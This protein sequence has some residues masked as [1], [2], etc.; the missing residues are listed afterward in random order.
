[1]RPVAGNP[2]GSRRRVPGGKIPPAIGRSNE[3]M[4]RYDRA[5]NIEKAAANGVEIASALMDSNK[6]P[7]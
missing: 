1:M 2:L 6:R 4:A 7:G 5:V 3:D